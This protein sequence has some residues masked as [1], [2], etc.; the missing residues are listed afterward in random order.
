[1]AKETLYELTLR[2]G[3][4]HLTTVLGTIQDCCK[5]ISLS[6][7]A[8]GGD[9]PVKRSANK[10]HFHSPDTSTDKL[11][12]QELA[13]GPKTV[14][15]LSRAFARAGFATTSTSILTELVRAGR[16][17]RL[18]RGMYRLADEVSVSKDLS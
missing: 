13:S 9:Q 2:V 4:Q 1:M 8:E 11:A 3:T 15:Q 6:P 10:R 5:I 14:L 18:G 7:V 16:V 17:I 12:L